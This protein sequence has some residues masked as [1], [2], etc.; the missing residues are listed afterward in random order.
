MTARRSIFSQKAHSNL[1]SSFSSTPI[2]SS[3]HHP[4]TP[5][6]TRS[7]IQLLALDCTIYSHNSF[8]ARP[9]CRKRGKDGRLLFRHEVYPDT[10]SDWPSWMPPSDDDPRSIS[11]HETEQSHIPPSSSSKTYTSRKRAKQSAKEDLDEP[12]PKKSTEKIPQKPIEK[13]AWYRSTFFR[14]F[15]PEVKSS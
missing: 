14:I 11:D 9:R 13:M 12:D 15:K 2:N 6:K 5:I 1:E 10:T 4:P 7:I 3:S 8:M